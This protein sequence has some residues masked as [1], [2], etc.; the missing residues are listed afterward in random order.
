[1]RV[2]PR[3]M[4]RLSDMRILFTIIDAN[5]AGG[6]RVALEVMQELR[7]G[8]VEL[9][10]AFPGTGPLEA[11]MRAIGVQT[12]YVPT[13]RLRDRRGYLA[14]ARLVRRIRPDLI[15]TH[16]A[17]GGEFIAAVVGKLWGIP[18]VIHRHAAPALTGSRLRQG[19]ERTLIRWAYSSASAVIAVSDATCKQLA[20]LGVPLA[21]VKTIKNA[22]AVEKFVPS[23][24]HARALV[25]SEF[26]L[27]GDSVVIS[28][29]GRLCENKGQRVLL[30]AARRLP[31][32]ELN[33]RFLLVGKDQ[34]QGGRY[35]AYLKRL[36]R[37]YGLSD[38]VV[39]AGYRDEV[40]DLL[41]ASD[42]T[43]LPSNAEA[44][45]LAIV[46]SMAA[47]KPVVATA[48]AGAREIVEDGIT[49]L[50]VPIDDAAALGQAIL[51]LVQDPRL[52]ATLAENA[53]AHV[54]AHF[55]TETFF[56]KVMGVL[57]GSVPQRRRHVLEL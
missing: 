2:P 25:R 24:P 55:D 21:R 7:A 49:G 31:C 26:G 11:A 23:S 16:C 13:W 47:K 42:M 52:G 36:A 35:E 50:I 46:E 40:A 34:E 12:E 57:S 45:G 1:V 30:E 6:Q 44:F 38:R 15:Y 41:A 27:A 53:Y 4:R 43:V 29:I 54:A 19:V 28:L 39:F 20:D 9:F 32:R 14:L 22:I 17:G 37:E 33:L 51:R 10:A 8:G 56:Q 3:A 18:V 48:T 5:L